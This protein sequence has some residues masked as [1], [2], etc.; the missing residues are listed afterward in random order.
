MG[1]FEAVDAADVRMVQRRERLRFALKPGEAIG[2]LRE[3]VGQNL[4]RDLASERRVA[5]AIDLAHAAGPNAET[6][7]YGPN[8]VP[9]V[10]ARVAYYRGNRDRDP[11][12]GR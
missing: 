4:Q 3:R 8:R 6:I 11:T 2:V 10:K 5:G 12:C 1:L 7:S 9:G